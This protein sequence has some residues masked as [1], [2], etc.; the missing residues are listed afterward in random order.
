MDRDR[1]VVARSI[2]RRK[3]GTEDAEECVG[4]DDHHMT[5]EAIDRCLCKH[6][7]AVRSFGAPPRNK[8]SIEPTLSNAL[9]V[10]DDTPSTRTCTS[11]F[12]ALEL[13]SSVRGV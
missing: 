4:G 5:T 10:I 3:L 6:A 9:L 11:T 1:H 2:D 13:L 12:V 8:V 7:Q